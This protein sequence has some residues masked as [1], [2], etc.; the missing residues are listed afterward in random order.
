MLSFAN[1]VGNFFNL[2]G[3]LAGIAKKLRAY[4]VDVQSVMTNVTNEK[5]ILQI[6]DNTLRGTTGMSLSQIFGLG[7]NAKSLQASGFSLTSALNANPARLGFAAPAITSS[8]IVG[9]T[10]VSAGDN[11]GA[12]ALQNAITRTQNFGAAGGI[13]SQAASLSDYAATFYQNL[14][15]Q[16][17]NITANQV[18]QGDRRTEAQ[19]RLTSHSGVNLDEELMALS[20]YQQAYAAGARMLTVVDQLYQT[21]LDI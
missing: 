19:T 8:S 13:A 15:T 14:S 1:A 16:S 3:R 17:N 11:A 18:T 5:V 21:L 6:N 7:S 10:I 9:S 20:S 4:Q 12:I 2:A